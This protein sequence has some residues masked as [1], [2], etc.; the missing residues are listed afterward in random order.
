MVSSFS[1]LFSFLIM[2]MVH[3]DEEKKIIIIIIMCTLVIHLKA[4]RKR[5]KSVSWREET[6]LVNKRSCAK[7]AVAP[8]S[9]PWLRESSASRSTES[10][11][12]IFHTHPP[13][14][15]LLPLCVCVYCTLYTV[16]F[17]SI[18]QRSARNKSVSAPAVLHVANQSTLSR[19]KEKESEG[20]DRI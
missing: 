16:G 2:I 4:K 13:P 18:H 10:E 19:E 5:R 9:L 14:I 3:R 17:L 6:T 8:T 15:S 20:N 12:I 1:S 7:S 11:Y